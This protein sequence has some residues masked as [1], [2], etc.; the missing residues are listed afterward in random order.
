MVKK[1]DILIIFFPNQNKKSNN[2][3]N[4]GTAP[5]IYRVFH[6]TGHPQI[7]AKSQALYKR[8]LDTWKFS[9]CLIL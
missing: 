2:H 3:D 5:P 6:D 8:E 9:K 4:H 1:C 7:L